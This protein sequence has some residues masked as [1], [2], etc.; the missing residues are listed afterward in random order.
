[1]T[2]VHDFH[3]LFCIGCLDVL[4][5]LEVFVVFHFVDKLHV[6]VMYLISHMSM[7]K[8]MYVTSFI[9]QISYRD[10]LELP[11]SHTGPSELAL[12]S[13]WSLKSYLH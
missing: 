7:M 6:S 13:K 4:D 11:P 1:M 5:V 9:Y 8:L 3:N 10:V 2:V 12:W